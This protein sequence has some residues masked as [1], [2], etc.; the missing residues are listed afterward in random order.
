DNVTNWSR[1]D[2]RRIKCKVGATYSTP[3][4][5]LKKAVDDINDMLVNH[6]NINNDMIMVYFDEFAAS[7]LN[8]F[9]YCF[10]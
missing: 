2:S 9:V 6:K 1:R 4:A 8:I 7:S 5:S 10:A 3:P